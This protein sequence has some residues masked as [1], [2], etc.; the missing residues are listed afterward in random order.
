M[1]DDAC[2]PLSAA[3]DRDGFAD[4]SNGDEELRWAVD[5]ERRNDAVVDVDVQWDGEGFRRQQWRASWSSSSK[6]MVLNCVQVKWVQNHLCPLSVRRDVDAG[7]NDDGSAPDDD[8]N[9]DH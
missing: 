4:D 8:G 5:G 7:E 2:I 9:C 6:R 3:D 1:G